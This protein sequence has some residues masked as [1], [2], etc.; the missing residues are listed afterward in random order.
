MKYPYV[1]FVLSFI[2]SVYLMYNELFRN[3]IIVEMKRLIEQVET[4]S[5]DDLESYTEFMREI[6]L[7]TYSEN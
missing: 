1:F 4:E 2:R 3:K 6:I 7:G 5:D